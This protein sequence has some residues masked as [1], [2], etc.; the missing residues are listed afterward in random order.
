MT[1]TGTLIKEITLS[2]NQSQATWDGTNANGKQLGTGVYL[3]A[4]NHSSEKNKVSKIAIIR[5]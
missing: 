4:A 2:A 1:I 3:V 5:K